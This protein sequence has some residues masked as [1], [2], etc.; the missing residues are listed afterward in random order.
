MVKGIIHRSSIGVSVQKLN[1]RIQVPFNC[2]RG[3]TQSDLVKWHDVAWALQCFIPIGR[4]AKLKAVVCSLPRWMNW[5]ESPVCQYCFYPCETTFHL[6][7]DCPGTAA[8]CLAHVSLL[9]FWCLNHQITSFAWLS[10]M[11]LF[12]TCLDVITGTVTPVWSPSLQLLWISK[13]NH[14]T[15][16]T[17]TITYFLTNNWKVL[18]LSFLILISP[19]LH[20]QTIIHFDQKFVSVSSKEAKALATRVT[21][22]LVSWSIVKL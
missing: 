10:L 11:P 19:S 8:V 17:T 2:V 18:P 21:C 13:A 16:Q 15:R 1:G 22:L 7:A 3:T 9:M 6:L 14:P 20:S 5:I 12:V 4:L